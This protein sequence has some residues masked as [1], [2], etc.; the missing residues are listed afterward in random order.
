MSYF[1]A[2]VTIA[3]VLDFTYYAY[4]WLNRKPKVDG[5]EFTRFHKYGSSLFT[6]RTYWFELAVHVDPLKE[7]DTTMPDHTDYAVE[8]V[9]TVYTNKNKIPDTLFIWIDGERFP[10]NIIQRLDDTE[11]SK[12]FYSAIVSRQM[13]FLKRHKPILEK[14]T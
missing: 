11:K 14:I 12:I 7:L 13:S 5:W 3:L 8:A 4:K 10:L 2:L 1:I 9:L 6:K